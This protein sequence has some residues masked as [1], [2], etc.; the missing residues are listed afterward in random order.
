MCGSSAAHGTSPHAA[1]GHI[2]WACHFELG[3]M[4]RGCSQGRAAAARGSVRR[5]PLTTLMSTL[6]CMH[7]SSAATGWCTA[8]GGGGGGR[9]ACGGRL[10]TAAELAVQASRSC[11]GRRSKCHGLTT[12]P[13]LQ[14]QASQQQQQQQPAPH[15]SAQPTPAPQAHQRGWPPRAG[16]GVTA[17]AT[18]PGGARPPTRTEQVVIHV[19]GNQVRSEAGRQLADVVAPQVARAALDRN[20]QR[21]RNVERRRVACSGPGGQGVGLGV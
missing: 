5:A 10:A 7:M 20:V 19:P 2:S 9:G 21:A 1:C 18:S 3:G 4:R 12:E 15:S 17:P 8:P 13:P 6:P 11:Q 16:Y 14:Q